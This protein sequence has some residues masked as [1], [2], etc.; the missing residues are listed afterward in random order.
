[1]LS[2]IRTI[3]YYRWICLFCFSRKRPIIDFKIYGTIDACQV[4]VMDFFLTIFSAIWMSQKYVYMHQVLQNVSNGCIL[5]PPLTTPSHL[6]H[7]S[8]DQSSPLDYT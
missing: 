2:M 8:D 1:M 6:L 7:N 5:L 4:G 3:Q